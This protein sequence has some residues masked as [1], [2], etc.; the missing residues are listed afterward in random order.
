MFW[1]DAVFND[2]DLKMQP[3]N[4]LQA[5]G[6]KAVFT[7]VDDLTFKVTFAAPNGFF[8]QNIA[9][10]N[11]DQMTRFPAHYFKQFHGKYN[12]DADKNAKAA[13]LTGWPQMFEQKG[14]V[15]LIDNAFK[16]ADMP[17]LSAWKMKVPM[18]QS[19]TQVVT[20][21]NPYYWKVDPDGNQ[22]PYFDRLNYALVT[23]EQ[24]LLLKVMQGE[25]DMI[26]Q[27]TATPNNKSVLF[28]NQKAGGYKFYDLLPTEPNQMVIQLNLTHTD[29]VKREL[30]ANKDFRIALSYGLNRKALIDAVFVGEGEPAQPSILTGDSLYN[31]RLAK[32]YTEY[33]VKKANE[34]LDK[35]IPKKGSDGIRLDA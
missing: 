9:W 18:G 20:E 8:L 17:V 6:K 27:Y 3:P 29:K 28:D 23:D 19:T 7:K 33:D 24:V 35:I 15:A 16:N 26:D 4:W 32:Q 13:N 11:N 2:P 1:Y 12:P 22:L 10:G 5:G 31:E 21:R 30:Y 25:I 34:I 14:G